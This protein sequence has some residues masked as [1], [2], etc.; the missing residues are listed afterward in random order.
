MTLSIIRAP[1]HTAR[2]APAVPFASTVV[3]AWLAG[4]GLLLTAPDTWA[5][6]PPSSPALQGVVSRVSDGDSL[7]FTPAGQA[8]I[9]VRLRDIDA[10]EICQDHGKE[11]RRALADLTLHKPALL[12]TVG[13]DRYGRVLGV[14][15]VDGSD[16]AVR[17]VEEGHAWSI[18]GK[19]DRGPLV[20]QE[21][22]AHALG[23]GLHGRAGAVMPKDFRQSHG[24]C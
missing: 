18:R 5:R 21:R 15:L 17:M 22:M 6:K 10:P 7:W 16:V 23:R 1:A 14:V 11:A 2:T 9:V 20:K 8:P 12:R 19:W 3:T 13:K 24:P 4:A